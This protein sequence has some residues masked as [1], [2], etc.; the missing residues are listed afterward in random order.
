VPQ[1]HTTAA[2]TP[3]SHL[4]HYESNLKLH[5]KFDFGVRAAVVCVWGTQIAL[6]LYIN[7]LAP[8]FPFKF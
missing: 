6:T 2:R 7:P 8:E 5:F 1:T 4:K 3:K